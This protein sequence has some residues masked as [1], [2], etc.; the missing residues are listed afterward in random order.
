MKQILTLARF[1]VDVFPQ[2]N[3]VY[4]GGNALNVAANCVGTNKADVFLMGNI[5]TDE[6]GERVAEMADK[7]KLNRER[8]YRV[9]GETASNKIY[10]AE[11]GERS[12]VPNAWN[13]GVLRDFEISPTDA[14]F[15]KSMDAVATTVN[16]YIFD[17]LLQIRRE[18]PTALLAV[19]FMDEKQCEFSESWREYLT[20]LDLFFI[21]GKPEY[22]PLLK[23][24]SLD[25]PE[26]VFTATLGEHGSVAFKGGDEFRC[27][28]AAVDKVVD[29]TGCGDSYQGAFIV[30]YLHSGDV[31]SAMEEGA[32]SA[33][34]T[35]GFVGAV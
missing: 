3:R 22:L 6:Y 16:D 13:D 29:T 11:D 32:K 2:Q 33:A 34:V 14:E 8:L 10:L 28:A 20:S 18:S 4:A 21:S 17:D 1:C 35:L 31:Q 19:D 15:I 12:F 23:R 9:E 27:G 24:W 25:F 7:Y 5:G 30:E 26:V